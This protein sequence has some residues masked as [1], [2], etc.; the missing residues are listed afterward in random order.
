MEVGH[1]KVVFFTKTTRKWLKLHHSPPLL[2]KHVN[3]WQVAQWHSPLIDWLID[4]DDGVRTR[5]WTAATS[6]PTVH[7]PSGTWAW[8]TM[9]EWYRQIKLLIRPRQLSGDHT[10]H[11]VA[12][13]RNGRR[14]W[15]IWRCE[16][17]LFTLFKRF[18]LHADM[19]LPLRRKSRCG[20]IALKSPSPRPGIITRTLGLMACTLT[21]TPP[22]R[23]TDICF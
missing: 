20:F 6:G 8:G 18:V 13:K 22:R 21:I 14:K 4:H 12:R 17:L 9:V 16:I 23:H 1:T 3:D 10:S 2:P 15:P 5:L 19:G 11:L 7:P